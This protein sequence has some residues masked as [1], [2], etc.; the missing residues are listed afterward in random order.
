MVDAGTTYSDV[1]SSTYLAK[2]TSGEQPDDTAEAVNVSD[3][4]PDLNETNTQDS[5]FP[6]LIHEL[7]LTV[8]C[9]AMPAT[10]LRA[11]IGILTL[12]F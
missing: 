1:E 11:Q 12:V 5:E 8:Q 6:L 10:P 7:R 3:Q 4:L 2:D 9:R